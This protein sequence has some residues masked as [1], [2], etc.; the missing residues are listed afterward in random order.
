MRWWK[1]M[2]K[3]MEFVYLVEHLTQL[4]PSVKAEAEKNHPEF[5]A[6]VQAM[7][8]L[9]HKNRGLWRR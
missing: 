1:R 3:A 8:D 5:A 2:R 4:W 6:T 7:D 9:W